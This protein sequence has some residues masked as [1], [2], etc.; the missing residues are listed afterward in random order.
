MTS[1]MPTRF[2]NYPPEPGVGVPVDDGGLKLL[3]GN[4]LISI[5]HAGSTGEAVDASTADIQRASL[6]GSG[7]LGGRDARLIANLWIDGD[8]EALLALR[9]L[10]AEPN[11]GEAYGAQ[12]MIGELSRSFE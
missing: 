3:T 10:A 2:E 1:Q 12:R 9:I 8:G 6:A 4:A 5:G 11:S 7:L